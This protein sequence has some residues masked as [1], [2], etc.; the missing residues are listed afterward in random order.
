MADP[1]ST[2]QLLHM[3]ITEHVA[4]GGK[5]DLQLEAP[6]EISVGESA[7]VQ[8]Y[9]RKHGLPDATVQFGST[10][11]WPNALRIVFSRPKHLIA[12]QQVQ[13]IAVLLA[14][15]GIVGF[16]GFSGWK[17]GSAISD[18]LIPL[19]LIGTAGAILIALTLS[20]KNTGVSFRARG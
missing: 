14:G 17:I 16:T 20:G 12:P 3:A 4:P 9:L 18:N 10:S 2:E 13:L 15:L 11:K 6:K 5:V 1:F 8:D 19:A 7:S